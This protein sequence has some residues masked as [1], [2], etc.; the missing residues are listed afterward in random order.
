MGRERESKGRDDIGKGGKKGVK[1]GE[2]REE[3]EWQHAVHA[4]I[5]ILGSRRLWM[6]LPRPRV[7]GWPPPSS[8]EIRH[9]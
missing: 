1:G 2:G 9:H 4:P 3:R 5:G 6:M 8:S 7:I